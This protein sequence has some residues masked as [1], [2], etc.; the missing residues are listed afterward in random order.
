[1]KVLLLAL[2]IPFLGLPAC[3]GLTT[4]PKGYTITEYDPDGTVDATWQADAVKLEPGRVTWTTLDG[5]IR[6]AT[7]SY[8]VV[9]NL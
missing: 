6:T 2:L 7:G 8:K 5:S 1:M 3:T 4:A 9:Q